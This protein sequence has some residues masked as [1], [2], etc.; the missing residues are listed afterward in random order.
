MIYI[1]LI[2]LYSY[3]VIKAFLTITAQGKDL[4][5][6][7]GP[8]ASIIE[9]F[10]IALAIS[11]LF[12]YYFFQKTEFESFIIPANYIWIAFIASI[13]LLGIGVGVRF[14]LS[15]MNN[16]NDEQ[17]SPFTR[18]QE[19]YEVFSG[20]WVNTSILIIFFIYSLMEIS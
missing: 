4:T 15:L 9:F 8:K 14:I 1:I 3:L 18:N 12:S 10:I 5:K 20:I 17:N 7:L 16:L 19:I 11:Y 6:K 13:F 2:S